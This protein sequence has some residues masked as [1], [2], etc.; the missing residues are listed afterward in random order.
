MVKPARQVPSLALFF[1]DL[2]KGEQART[3][4]AVICAPLIVPCF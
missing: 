3:H 1:R 2:K 4:F